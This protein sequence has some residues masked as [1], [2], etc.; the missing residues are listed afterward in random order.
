MNTEQ[1]RIEQASKTNKTAEENELDRLRKNICDLSSKIRS[2]RRLRQIYTV[3]H[4]AFLNDRM[5]AL[6][7]R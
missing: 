4:R 3:A 2:E 7:E 5:E 6:N 1:C